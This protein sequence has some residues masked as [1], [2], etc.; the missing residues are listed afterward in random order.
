MTDAACAPIE[1]KAHFPD[2]QR[3]PTGAYSPAVSAGGLVVTSG[4][5]GTDPLTGAVAG[6]GIATQTRACLQNV[7]R[8]LEAA[9]V[10]LDRVV[11]T[12]VYLTRAE[13][14]AGMDAVFHEFFPA[15]HP[16]RSTVTVAALARPAFLVEIDAL[17][18]R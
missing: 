8:A 18:V 10:T 1:I 9:G 16:A 15:P 13:D 5:V 4:Q 6:D 17:A 7:Q 3:R 11:K 12:T 14:L 2:P